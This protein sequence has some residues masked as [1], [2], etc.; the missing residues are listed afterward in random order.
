MRSRAMALGVRD[1]A[2]CAE[3]ARAG[4]CT[5]DTAAA[6]GPRRVCL[7]VCGLRPGF[8]I[9]SNLFYRAATLGRI[10]SL[11]CLKSMKRSVIS[12]NHLGLPT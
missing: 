5:R 12:A 4:A 1:A 9:L 2:T 8:S 3:Q 10:G 6:A 11:S 7:T